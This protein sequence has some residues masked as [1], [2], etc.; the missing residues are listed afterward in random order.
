MN[1]TE[2][3]VVMEDALRGHLSRRCR[4]AYAHDMRNGL[5]GIY[6][7]VDA[8]ARAARAAK[9]TSIPL[10]QVAQFVQQAITNHERG[11]ERILESIAPEDAVIAPVAV[12]ELMGALA[13]FLTN[14]AA[15]NGVRLKLDLG[16]KMLA[17]V[18][19]A[20]LRLVFL[21]L[22]TD[23]IDSIPAGGDIRISGQARGARLQI[24]FAYPRTDFHAD[25]WVVKAVDDLVAQVSGRITR[26][27]SADHGYQVS[28]DLPAAPA[29]VASQ[30]TA[31]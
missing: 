11:L 2:W 23:A 1:D 5:Q 15:R 26:Q 24:D 29:E 20:Q 27:R 6:G 10:E 19:P 9:P 18:V 12:D 22:L 3:P 28:L 31:G 7:G 13:R 4:R 30:P 25:S 16:G 21:G 17:A 14:D 8:L